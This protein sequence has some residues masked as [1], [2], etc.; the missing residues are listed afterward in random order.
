MPLTQAED[1]GS[2]PATGQVPLCGKSASN[3]LKNSAVLLAGTQTGVSAFVKEE[4][5]LFIVP[6]DASLDFCWGVIEQKA[7]LWAW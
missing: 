1:C 5:S 6:L 7:S 4:P 3:L 2:Q